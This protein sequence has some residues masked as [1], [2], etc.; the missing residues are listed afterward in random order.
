MKQRRSSVNF[1]SCLRYFRVAKASSFR[2]VFQLREIPRMPN[3]SSISV[4][5]RRERPIRP[6]RR[7]K[8]AFHRRRQF[9]GQ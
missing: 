8:L 2:M 7:C 9:P 6:G 3:F 1:S 5:V 4:L